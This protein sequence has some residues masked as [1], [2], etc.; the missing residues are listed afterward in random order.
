MLLNA[1][2]LYITIAEEYNLKH[3]FSSVMLLPSLGKT[4]VCVKDLLK[5]P[6]EVIMNIHKNVKLHPSK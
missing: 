5:M 4:M 6:D 1:G 3:V 2:K